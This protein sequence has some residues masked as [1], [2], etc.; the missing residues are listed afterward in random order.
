MKG[1]APSSDYA[2]VKNKFE[3]LLGEHADSIS[4]RQTTVDLSEIDPK[5]FSSDSPSNI[6]GNSPKGLEDI[7]NWLL[8]NGFANR[9]EFTFVI[10]RGVDGTEQGPDGPSGTTL[11]KPVLTK[12][13]NGGYIF[14]TRDT[15]VSFLGADAKP[16]S[17]IHEFGHQAGLT[18][19]R[20]NRVYKKK[21][22]FSNDAIPTN[23]RRNP[24]DP[25]HYRVG[26]DHRGFRE[27]DIEILLKHACDYKFQSN[28]EAKDAWK[29]NRKKR[30]RARER[31]R[32]KNKTQGGKK[33]K[34]AR[35]VTTP[36]S[37]SRSHMC[38][39]PTLDGTPCERRVAPPGFCWQHR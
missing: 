2:T 34:K 6:N 20:N 7:Y 28:K 4:I 1:K 13:S 15:N 32:K 39:A 5:H 33:K 8:D 36:G 3:S 38:G 37:S 22:S 18:H 35:S 12:D 17:W 19:A 16:Y 26:K 25:M 24:K 14:D 21:G 30:D 11:G 10:T 31:I 23:V 9:N 27:E 29:K